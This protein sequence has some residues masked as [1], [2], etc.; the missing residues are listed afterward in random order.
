MVNICR[1]GPPVA[2][3]FVG[4]QTV[5]SDGVATEGHPYK[6]ALHGGEELGV[7]LC[8]LKSFEHDLHLLNR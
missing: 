2:A 5:F 8:L 3:P 6:L 7:R 4:N 1:G